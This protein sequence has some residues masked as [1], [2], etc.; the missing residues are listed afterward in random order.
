MCTVPD[1]DD[2]LLGR[3]ERVGGLDADALEAGREARDTSLGV[4][5]AGRDTC[6]KSD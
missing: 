2:V 5:V 3:A 4:R 6:T 1:D